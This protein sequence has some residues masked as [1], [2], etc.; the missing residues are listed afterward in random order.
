MAKLMLLGVAMLCLAAG[1]ALAW[2]H[3]LWPTPLLLLFGLWCVAVARRPAWWLFG[4][5]ALL[6]LLNFSPWTG[7]LMV[8]EFDLLLL[9]TLAGGYYS[10]ACRAPDGAVR[11]LAD[12]YPHWMLAIGLVGVVGLW[13]GFLDAGSWQLDWFAGYADATNSLR[14]FKSLGFALLLSPLLRREMLRDQ[15]RA[16]VLLASG[17]VAGLTVV[18]MAALWERAAFPGVTDFS[19]HYRTVA[20]FWEMHVGGAALDA[21]LALA[22]P[23]ALWALLQ[24]RRPLAWLGA[25]VL[26]VLVV[27]A[28]LTTF[29]RG[30]YLAV[31]AP[32][33]LLGFLLWW[34]GHVGKVR[35]LLNQERLRGWFAGWRAKAGVVLAAAL[36]MEVTAVLGGGNFMAERIADAGQDFGS[37]VAHWKNGLGL[38]D[39]PT[40]QWLGLGLGRLPTNYARRVA[41]GEFSGEVHWRSELVAGQAAN[42]FVS[43][44]GPV[45]QKNLAGGFELTQRV[46][47]VQPGAHGVRLNVRVW[48]EVALELYLCE[49]HLLYDRVCQ[50]AYV[51][52]APVAV[53]G[54]AIWQPLMVSL[55]GAPI[56]IGTGLA[57][58]LMMFSVGVLSAGARVDLD[59]VQLFGSGGNAVLKNGDF[60]DGLAHWFGAAQSYFLPWHLDNLYLELLVER[61]ILGFLLLL[62]PVIFVLWHLVFRAASRSTLAPY[63][64]AALSGALLTGLVSSIMD[65]P[66]VAFLLL[67]FTLMGAQ[68]TIQ[69]TTAQQ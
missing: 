2:H 34:P 6:P 31:A 60:A 42:A 21:Y 29:S 63:L 53:N 33:L 66:R 46:G 5:P 51:R 25:A 16:G 27:Y 28:A 52:V 68:L 47:Q 19:S 64:A 44:T 26:L 54:Q 4:V 3:P 50:S 48:R 24:A 12:F 37:R 13:R 22:A 58:R 1:A 57:P 41:G 39:Q 10:L 65:V 35:A 59:K 61:G 8:E 15:T 56:S 62:V 49:R 38:L 17:M 30:V 11:R 45:S 7:W 14:V 32:A 36:V 18:A 55:R 40:V 67:L 43:M 20:L 9:A 69:N 23:F